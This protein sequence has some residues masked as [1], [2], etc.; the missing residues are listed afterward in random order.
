MPG[1]KPCSGTPCQ[2]YSAGH[3]V[4]F[5]HAKHIARTPWQWRDALVTEVNGD[6]VAV[7]Y[8]ESGH[9]LSLWHHRPLGDVLSV[10]SPVRLHE[11]YYVIGGPFGWISVVISNG[12]GT[13]PEPDSPEL[14]AADVVVP[15]VDLHTGRALPMDHER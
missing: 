8:V 9:E 6:T 10:G 12:L 13:L 2:S 4:H 14:F 1:L 5:I 3:N 11:K 15:V 7:A